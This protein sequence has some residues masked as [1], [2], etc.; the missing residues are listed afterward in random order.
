[1]YPIRCAVK[2]LRL[3]KS[4]K[5]V[6]KRVNQYLSYDQ[7]PKQT[8]SRPEDDRGNTHEAFSVGAKAKITKL[9]EAHYETG[10][11][12]PHSA[13][14]TE[15]HCVNLPSAESRKAESRKMLAKPGID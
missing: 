4:Q 8:S 14:T 6:I 7:R 1:M 5:K 2:N 15:D 11:Q 9:A 10:S 12:Q 3:S 13:S